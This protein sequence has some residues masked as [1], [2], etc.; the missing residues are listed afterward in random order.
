MS[1][2]V[3]HEC[4]TPVPGQET[5]RVVDERRVTVAVIAKDWH[6]KRL[7]YCVLRHGLLVHAAATLSDAIHFVREEDR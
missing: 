7:A 5:W 6:S 4:G 3:L 1:L 2:S